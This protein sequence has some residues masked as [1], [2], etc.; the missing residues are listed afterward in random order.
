MKI[1]PNLK[2]VAKFLIR[3]QLRGMFMREIQIQ[4]V[5]PIESFQIIT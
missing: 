3:I 2:D 1:M 4:I 5:R